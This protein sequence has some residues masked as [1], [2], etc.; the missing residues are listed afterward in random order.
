MRKHI[1]ILTLLTVLGTLCARAQHY[2]RG[3]DAV[4]EAFAAKGTWVVGGSASYSQHLNSD[5]S[6]F[7]IDDINS[8]GYSIAASPKVVYMFRDNLGVG[9]K[10]SY[11]RSMLD[12]ASANLSVSEISMSASNCYQ[13]NHDYV[14]YGLFR[15]YIPVAG[16]RRIAM[17]ADLMLGGSFGQGKAYN[18]GGSSVV[19]T[20]EQNYKVRLAVDPGISVFLTDNLALEMNL[21]IFGVSYSW[22]NQ[23]H[24]Q[25]EK[26][27]TDS[28]SAGFMM[29]FLSLGVGLYYYL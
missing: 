5:Y 27:N 6:L 23:I 26:G 2:D 20:Y 16:L 7:I 1:V 22:K 13:I 12:L 18:A 29:N 25:A 10:C 24:N 8:K 15:A 19:G 3:Y 9:F 17:F 4:Q 14:A 28:V 11:S 21:G